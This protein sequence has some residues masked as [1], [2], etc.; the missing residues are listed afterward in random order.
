MA[1]S[2]TAFARAAKEHAESRAAA[3]TRSLYLLDLERWLA[4]CKTPE[5]PT[6]AQATRFRDQL[7]AKAAA[8]TVRRTITALSSMYEAACSRERPLATWNPFKKLPRPSADLYART[9][10]ISERD[11]KAILVAA[12]ADGSPRGRRD[13]VI[14]HLLYSTGLRRSSV[15][16]LRWSDRYQQSTTRLRVVVKGGKLREVELPSSV[17]EHLRSWALLFGV[18]AMATSEFMFPSIKNPNKPITPSAINEIVRLR[19]KQA[20]L[21]GIHP[22]QFRAAYVTA[23]LDAGV[24]LHEV[25]ASVHHAS[26]TTTLRYD[27]GQRGAGVTSA[28]AKHR[29]KKT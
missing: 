23:A 3:G 27:R 19:A 13:A 5:K 18:E 4:F 1:L 14:L 9:E 11:A 7:Q 29:A 17:A 15:A 28:V 24:P 21:K 25:Q 16:A 6:L 2:R 12:E 20:G 26:P 10:A 8:Q 22:H